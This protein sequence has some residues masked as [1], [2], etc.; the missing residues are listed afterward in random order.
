MVQK[1]TTM[2]S[3]NKKTLINKAL[4]V[5]GVAAG[6]IVMA[7]AAGLDDRQKVVVFEGEIVEESEEETLTHE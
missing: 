5:A 4:V 2:V 6:F 7:V 1:I 3:E